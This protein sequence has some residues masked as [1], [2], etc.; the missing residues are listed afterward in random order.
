MPGTR[1]AHGTWDLLV[2]APGERSAEFVPRA[3][4]VDLRLG[5]RLAV[6]I[7]DLLSSR[8]DATP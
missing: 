8:C 2:Q 4:V 3:P 1:P 5:G 6:G 7:E